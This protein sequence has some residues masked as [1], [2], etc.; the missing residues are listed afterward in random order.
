M[1]FVFECLNLGGLSKL[2]QGQFACLL[3]IRAQDRQ[4]ISSALVTV[5]GSVW[6]SLVTARCM[7][8]HRHTGPKTVTTRAS[9]EPS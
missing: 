9:N 3:K 4:R 8:R 2:Q 6:W 1:F 5:M 7:D